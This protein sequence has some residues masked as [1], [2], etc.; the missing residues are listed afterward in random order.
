[1]RRFSV[2]TR[3]ARFLVVALQRAR[4]IVVDDETDVRF[5][6]THPEGSGRH[7]DVGL[8]VRAQK[9]RR[10]GQIV[11]R[12]SPSVRDQIFFTGFPRLTFVKTGSDDRRGCT[13]FPAHKF[14]LNRLAVGGVH[15]RVVR[16]CPAIRE[17][18]NEFRH[19]IGSF[20]AGCVHDARTGMS[21]QKFNEQ[22][23]F[24]LLT[25]CLLHLEKEVGPG[26]TT[27]EDRRVVQGQKLDDVAPYH[28]GGGGGQR[29]G[30]WVPDDGTELS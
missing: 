25:T 29:D 14:F 20:S 19:L 16:H 27:N 15:S 28:V 18:I 26:K 12:F 24:I 30:R 10:I 6:D 21:I 22:V 7:D 3:A 2:P 8:A 11:G 4:H 17:L 13:F 9:F 1:M 5:I 23:F